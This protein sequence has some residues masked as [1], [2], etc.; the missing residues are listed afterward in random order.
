M[1]TALTLLT[2]AMASI[3]ALAAGPAAEPADDVLA[4]R[5]PEIRFKSV[6]IADVLNML[7]T[8]T[9]VPITANWGELKKEGVEK[10]TAVSLV[11][12]NSTLGKVLDELLMQLSPG[13]KLTL[14]VTKQQVEVT[15][16]AATERK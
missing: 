4:T 5:I 14:V 9:G 3:C 12:K 8:G 6:A 15:T 2:V 7:G 13:K 16:K 10:N 1:R 11:A